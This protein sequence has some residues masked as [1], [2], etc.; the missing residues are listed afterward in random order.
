MQR[1]EQD[2][3]TGLWVANLFRTSMTSLA[4]VQAD[5]GILLGSGTDV[6]LSAADVVILDPSNMAR[7]I[8]TIFQISP[9]TV[10]RIMANFLWAFMYTYCRSSAICGGCVRACPYRCMTVLES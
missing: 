7:S 6:A 2:R 4:L 8:R 9:G 5:I 10:L 1:Y 3:H